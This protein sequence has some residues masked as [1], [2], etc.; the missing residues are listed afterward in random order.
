MRFLAVFKVLGT[1]LMMLSLSQLP[2]TLVAYIY[3]DGA[4]SAFTFSF[5]V[6][7][8]FGYCL[9][10]FSKRSARE[11][12]ARDGFLVVSL[13][14]LVLSLFS[15]IPLIMTLYPKLTITE[16][17]FEAVSG[18][19]TTGASAMPHLTSIPHA[20][21]YYRQQ[22]HFLGG[23]GII[24]LA[25]AVLPMLGVGGMQLYR[26]E[27]AG[28]MDSDKLTPRLTHTAKAL[29]YLYFGLTLC[30]AL[31]YRLAGMDWFQAVSASFTTV[32]TGGFSLHESSFAYYNSVPIDVIGIVFMILG[33]T[34]FSL[35]FQLAR[36]R[37]PLVYF[38]D[39]EFRLYLI[40][41]LLVALIIGSVLSFHDYYHTG[42]NFLNALFTV[43]SIGT[44]TGLTTTNFNLWPSF[45]PFLLMFI[46]VI[47]GSA[48]STSG[49]VKMVRVLVL[50]EQAKRELYR[51]IHPKAVYAVKLGKQPLSDRTLQAVWGF[52]AA[53]IAIFGVLYL[54][55][56]AMGLDMRTA[57]GALVA[58]LSNTGVGIGQ[59]A[60]GFS[61]LSVAIKWV[62]IFS[63]IAGRLEIFTI[64]ILLT[65]SYW[66]N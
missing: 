36:R 5:I 30:C 24:V 9:W 64:I 56:V 38:R 49:G 58:C 52:V 41:Y 45:V 33:A 37:N 8:V 21:L 61:G 31:S 54:I 20:I 62:L 50:Y 18:L 34:N 44:T 29:W 4:I 22:L 63:M 47:G 12:K 35:H 51:L 1:V 11:L 57:F 15:A 53:Y 26:A 23:M 25:V 14:W 43:V 13:L 59:V 32:S 16:A 60:D 28:P 40:F 27:V 19:T 66:R 39:A 65:P 10:L 48:G 46:A 55:L 3:G 2:P 42:R 17:V 6:T 7:F